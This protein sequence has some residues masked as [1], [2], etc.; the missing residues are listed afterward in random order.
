MRSRRSTSRL[1]MAA[2]VVRQLRVGEPLANLLRLRLLAL[3]EL[4]LDRL[5]LLA[6]VVLP[7]R[8]RHL[9]LGRGL[10]LALQLEQRHFAAEGVRHRLQLGD[11]IVRFQ[12][13]LFLVGLDVEQG[14]QHVGQPQRIVDAQHQAA[15]FLRQTARQRQRAID[16]LLDAPDVGVD[17]DRSLG[18]F[19]K[20][21]DRRAQRAL[22]TDHARLPSRAT[23]LRRR[24]G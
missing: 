15:Q 19:G 2:T 4:V 13:P 8:G 18:L 9:L 1:A 23:C 20:R 6:E 21:R 7:L 12:N 14:R 10:D 5:E 11:R 24:P 3:A 22:R 17:L 16:Q